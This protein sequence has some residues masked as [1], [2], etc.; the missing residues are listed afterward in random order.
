MVVLVARLA[1][2][3][4]TLARY[5]RAPP[6]VVQAAFLLVVLC[7]PAGHAQQ[8]WV[9]IEY[10]APPDC[11]ERRTLRAGAGSHAARPP[12]GPGDLAQTLKSPSKVSRAERRAARIRRQRHRFAARQALGERRGMR[13]VVSG[14]ALVTAIAIDARAEKQAAQ[15][16]PVRPPS[17]RA[18]PRAESPPKLAPVPRART[19]SAG[20]GARW[21]VG[22]GFLTTSAVA[23]SL[24]Y[25]L[26]AFVAVGP[27][28]PLVGETDARLPRD[29]NLNVAR[30]EASFQLHL[31]RAEACLFGPQSHG[32][33]GALAV[34]RVRCR[35]RGRF[36][37][38]GSRSEKPQAF[39]PARRS[40]L[41]SSWTC[42]FL[43][44]RGPGGASHAVHPRALLFREPRSHGAHGRFGSVGCGR[45]GRRAF[46]SPGPAARAFFP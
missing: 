30:G 31:A 39:C 11:T 19:E 29:P 4:T 18:K 43:T 32:S 2:L 17:E 44:V 15:A 33:P 13:E 38:A 28:S 3:V 16:P 36:R 5:G 21:D 9:R 6:Q 40:S 12:G 26:D 8:S 37:V 46:L 34:R 45:G 20:A 41:A 10:T 24:L 23:P 27:R 1:P 7:A 35:N 14:I 22:L 42:R 25:G